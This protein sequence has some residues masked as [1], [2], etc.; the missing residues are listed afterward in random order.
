MSTYKQSSADTL[1]TLTS[2]PDQLFT[3]SHPPPS[4]STDY[5]T[6][7]RRRCYLSRTLVAL[8]VSTLVTWIIAAAVLTKKE[9]SV[10]LDFF[11]GGSTWVTVDSYKCVCPPYLPSLIR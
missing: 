9:L 2:E 4:S 7:V 11:D 5:A 3:P 1:L 6:D 10:P 8:A